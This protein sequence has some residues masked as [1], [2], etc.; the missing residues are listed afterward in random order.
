MPIL[1]LPAIWSLLSCGGGDPDGDAC[2]TGS[3]DPA[4]WASTPWSLVP[5]DPLTP[6]FEQIQSARQVMRAAGNDAVYI[7]DSPGLTVRILTPSWAQ[8]TG[9]W[10][11]G[12]AGTPQDCTTGTL[13]TSGVARVTES[14]AA[15]LDDLADKL[16]LVKPL[17]ARLDV[18]GTNRAGPAWQTYNRAAASHPVTKEDT[19]QLDDACAARDGRIVLAGKGQLALLDPD[20]NVQ[21]RIPM[22]GT[23][24]ALHHVGDSGWLAAFV[25]DGSAWLI[26]TTR[27]RAAQIVPA[28]G[29]SALAVDP[30]RQAVWVARTGQGTLLR[31]QL[32]ASGVV[33]TRTVSTCGRI[34]QLAVDRRT[35]AV[36]ALSRC[37]QAASG[38][39]ALVLDDQGIR[40]SVALEEVPITLVPPGAMGQ[41]AVLVQTDPGKDTS[42][43]DIPSAAAVRAW[44]VVDPVDDRP[45]LSLWVVTTLEEP[46]T[47]AGMACTP[48]ESPTSNFQALVTQLQENIPA[49]QA[50][51]LPVAVGVTWEFASKA[52]A[53]GLDGVLSELQEAGFT[54][55]T[56]I[57]DKPCYS[58]TDEEVSGQSPETCGRNDPDWAAA[59]DP[60]ACWPSDPDYC[61]RGDQACWFDWVGAKVLDVD[62]W[63]PGGSQFIFGADRHRLW[64]YEYIQH[65]YRSFP[66]AD[67]GTGYRISM[68]QGNWI[69]EDIQSVD[70]PRAKDAAPWTPE[71][72]GTTWFPADGP[73]WEQDSAF[74][75]LLYMPGSS[76]ALS[77]LYD[78]ERSDL[79][80]V[81]LFD[82]VTPMIVTQED[83]DT[84]FA[85]IAQP[86]A[87]RTDRPGTWYFHLAD[88]TGYPLVPPDDRV[89]QQALLTA[90]RE[91]V[92]ATYGPAGMG[93]ARWQGPLEARQAVDDWLAGAP[94]DP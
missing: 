18:V 49:L 63:I 8:P 32:D 38:Y 90:L 39:E 51:G 44:H 35:G 91:R 21:A 77:R 94:A 41:L 57:H 7:V 55:G 1:L 5:V 78:A 10:C 17:G 85:A 6:T 89:D 42:G 23:I 62:Q 69:Y 30:D 75:D 16:Y 92:E 27:L 86:V 59:D 83:L 43:E 74:S 46:F 71:L 13:V 12:G 67:G 47:N 82:E 25:E 60:I 65:G 73:G 22:S 19:D 26:S 70:D 50:T 24:R 37:G 84:A 40:A 72:L 80:L 15:C 64:G 76:T 81:H 66:R 52:R 88:L 11:V 33:E 28:D 34:E 93:V 54:L 29:A 56:M 3:D 36:H 2:C 87:H 4:L 45:P 53:C 61:S 68:F 79:S 9:E 31:L 14:P 58:C 20:F 48:A